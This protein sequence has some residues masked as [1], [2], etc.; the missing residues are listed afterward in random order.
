[1]TELSIFH[2]VALYKKENKIR[3][4]IQASRPSSTKP[5]GTKPPGI[6]YESAPPSERQRQKYTQ[7]I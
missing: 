7:P 3:T 5:P 2:N 4:P 1:M 6:L